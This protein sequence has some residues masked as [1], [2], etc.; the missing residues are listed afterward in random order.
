MRRIFCAVVLGLFVTTG[1]AQAAG[2]KDYAK[3]SGTSGVSVQ[4]FWFNVETDPAGNNPRGTLKVQEGG[5]EVVVEVTCMRVI[6]TPTGGG[7]AVIAGDVLRSTNFPA[8]FDGLVAYVRDSGQPG[9]AGDFFFA[10]LLPD[11]PP[12]D[13]CPAPAPGFLLTSGDITLI[14]E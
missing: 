2:P 8:A 10:N 5:V 9:G 4:Q 12:E 6:G 3:G 1:V 7:T 11:G 14:D 13:A